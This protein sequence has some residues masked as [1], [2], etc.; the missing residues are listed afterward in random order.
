MTSFGTSGENNMVK[1][2]KK[3]LHNS[4]FHKFH[5]P[6]HQNLTKTSRPPLFRLRATAGVGSVAEATP[7][8]DLA[9]AESERALSG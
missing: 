3:D 2:S 6:S 7:S 9:V 4:R 5:I 1:A 8:D